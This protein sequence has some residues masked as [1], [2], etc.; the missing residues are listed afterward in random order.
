MKFSRSLAQ[1]LANHAVD[2]PEALALVAAEQS[3]TWPELLAAA[4]QLADT[5]PAT[6]AIF[7]CEGSSLQLALNAYACSLKK[8]PFWPVDRTPKEAL[9]GCN[10]YHLMFLRSL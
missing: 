2:A 3:Y 5:I 6:P 10:T 8:Q 4:E 1:H 7:S 9:L